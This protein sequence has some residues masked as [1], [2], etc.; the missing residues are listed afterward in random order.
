MFSIQNRFQWWTRIP[1]QKLEPWRRYISLFIGQ[2]WV[3]SLHTKGPSFN[4]LEN[5]RVVK[6][7]KWAWREVLL[8]HKQISFVVSR[9][10]SSLNW[11]LNISFS[12]KK[13][14]SDL[15]ILSCFFKKFQ[16]ASSFVTI[17]GPCSWF[18]NYLQVSLCAT[19]RFFWR[20]KG[21]FNWNNERIKEKKR[22]A[23]TTSS[24]T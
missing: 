11:T 13:S 18:L 23:K 10:W 16:Y 14:D 5:L 1:I 12:R 4:T 6:L 3:G 9:P 15:L 17:F 24:V 20:K 2:Y 7:M 8:A 19:V 22:N 21:A